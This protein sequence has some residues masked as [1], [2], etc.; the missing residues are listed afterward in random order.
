MLLIG[1]YNVAAAVENNWQLLK[2]LNLELQYD[3][4]ISFL[5]MYPKELKR[6]I[7]RNTCTWVFLAVLNIAVHISQKVETTQKYI[8][9]WMA[10]Q[11]MVYPYNGIL[12][13]H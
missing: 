9:W 12:L 8:D 2:Q 7:Q 6:G 1:V 3:T 11:N 13:S 10:N 4:N 5:R